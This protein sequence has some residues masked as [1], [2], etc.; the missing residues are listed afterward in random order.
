MSFDG[1]GWYLSS[2]ASLLY[3]SYWIHNWVA[4]L[5]IR[6]FF[7]GSGAICSPKTC[8]II[9]RV[10]LTTLLL[11]AVPLSVQIVNNFMFFNNINDRYLA[12][13]PYETLMRHVHCSIHEVH[14][15]I[16]CLQRPVVGVQLYRSVLGNP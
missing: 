15:L 16:Y 3:I 12:F 7:K 8:K 9:A 10:Y 5:K 14:V 4:W 1:Y 13:R 2:T 6:P 11:S